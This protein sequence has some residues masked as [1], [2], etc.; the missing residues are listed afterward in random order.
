M[1]DHTERDAVRAGTPRSRRVAPLVLAATLAVALAGCDA[2]G[3]RLRLPAP[4]AYG[5]VRIDEGDRGA[6]Y[7][8]AGLHYDIVN[9]SP[10]RLVEI[11]F[12]FDLY[13]GD[14]PYP[15]PGRNSFYTVVGCAV[16]PGSSVSFCTSLDPVVGED[17][18][19]LEVAR[20]RARLVRFEDGS[21]WRNTG[22][23]VYEEHE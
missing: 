20:F 23:H 5:S 10:R 19:Y 12:A 8:R 2:M 21:V 4:I 17:A 22:A 18:Q 7:R 6:L 15:D 14:D 1:T 9:V 16:P 13:H 11:E 3:E